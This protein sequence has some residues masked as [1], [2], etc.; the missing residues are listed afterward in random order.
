MNLRTITLWAMYNPKR[1]E[2]IVTRQFKYE[3]ERIHRPADCV[4]VKLKGHYV[5]PR[6]RTDRTDA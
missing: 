2:L 6:A 4:L 3:I 5:L 1:R